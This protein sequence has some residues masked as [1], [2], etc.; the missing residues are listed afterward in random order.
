[1]EITNWLDL[2]VDESTLR[3]R[4][5]VAALAD[6]RHEVD[7]RI[8][9][10][11]ARSAQCLWGDLRVRSASIDGGI[12]FELEGCPNTL[13][14]SVCRGKGQMADTVVVHAS[15]AGAGDDTLKAS[16]QAFVDEVKGRVQ[17]LLAADGSPGPSPTEA[18]LPCCGR[19]ANAT[20]LK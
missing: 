5:T 15:L 4:V 16:V 8:A 7:S 13:A 17:G 1:M 12:R 10:G 3:E 6:L 2:A 20:H 18:E 14:W 9:C 11:G 19:L